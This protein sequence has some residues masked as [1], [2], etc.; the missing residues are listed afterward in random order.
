MGRALQALDIDPN[1][2]KKLSDILDPDHSG[3]ISIHELV[4]G[5]QRLRGQPRRSDTVMVDL[6]VRALQKMTEDIGKEVHHIAV[7]L[8]AQRTATTALRS[9]M[10]E[11]RVA[12]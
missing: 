12:A 4:N 8:T 5:L 7:S 1:D 10:Q 2:H 9:G 11:I 6:M 3:T